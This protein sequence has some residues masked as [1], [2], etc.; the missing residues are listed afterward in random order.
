MMKRRLIGSAVFA[1]LAGAAGVAQAQTDPG[2]ILLQVEGNAIRTGEIF[3]DGSIDS[4]QRLFTARLGEVVPH[5]TDEPGFDGPP[6]TFTPG[7]RIGIRV[8]DALRVWNG[9]NFDDVSS[10]NLEIAFSTLFMTTPSMPGVI[11]GFSLPVASNGEWHRHLEYT[12]LSPAQP[13]VYLLAMQLTSNAGLAD[14]LPFWIIVW[15]NARTPDV[16]AA[17]AWAE[18]QL[19]GQCGCD[20]DLNR[21]GNADQGDIDYLINVVAGGANPT[22]IDPDFSGD[23]NVDQGD[24]DAVLNVIAGGECP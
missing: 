24:I 4:D 10:S 21:D 5:F 23:G 12:L 1:A 9:S 15:E 18:C 13:G 14:S 8:L 16:E 20:P 2:D 17:R 11:E 19:L 6:G 22:G 3:E 7:S